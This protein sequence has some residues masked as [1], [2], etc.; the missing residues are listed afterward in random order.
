LNSYFKKDKIVE[1][2]NELPNKLG[3]NYSGD[4]KSEIQLIKDFTNAIRSLRKN[5]LI[6]PAEKLSCYCILTTVDRK[7]LEDNSHIIE[8]LCNLDNLILIE[9]EN[10]LNL[11]S[12]ITPSGVVSFIKNNNLDFSVQIEKLNK[13]LISLE[14]TLTLSK[15]KLNN[16]GFLE[17]A[18]EHIIEEEKIK[19]N[20]T[21]S[22]ATDIRNLISQ[23]N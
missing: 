13:D 6:T 21:N 4:Y 18:P 11:I 5:L 14:K 20:D 10:D 9:E 7:F 12:N 22:L 2:F 15:S 3:T 1:K 23:L 16:K 17:S 8:K 19:L